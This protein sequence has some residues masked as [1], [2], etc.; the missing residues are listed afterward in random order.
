MAKHKDA[1][2][3]HS[4]FSLVELSIVVI[5]IALIITGILSAKSL[6]T[7]TAL[8]S[9]IREMQTAQT[10]YNNFFLRY[11]AKPGDFANASNFWSN[12]ADTNADCNGNGN[13]IIEYSTQTIDANGVGDEVVRVY[14]H[15]SLANMSNSAGGNQLLHGV[16]GGN[17]VVGSDVPG[18][19]LPGMGYFIAGPIADIGNGSAFASPWLGDNKTNA[20]YIGA[21]KAGNGLVFSSLTAEDAFSIDKKIDDGV[22]DNAYNSIGAATGQFRAIDGA[23]ATQFDCQ[24]NNLYTIGSDKLACIVGLSLE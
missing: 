2:L 10:S 5:I 21:K 20:V 9:V 19:K 14:R 11:E 8:N 23:D 22:V 13:R 7:Q 4:G 16:S 24:N 6:I 12:C 17:L 18:S 15:F 3:K 1:N